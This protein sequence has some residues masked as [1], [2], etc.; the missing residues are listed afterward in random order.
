MP[1]HPPAMAYLVSRYPAISHT[2]ILREVQ[3][4]R[5]LG[6]TLFT[7]SINPPDRPVQAMEGYE[8]KR[9]KPLFLSRHKACLAPWGPCCSGP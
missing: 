6:H 2:F 7:A 4:L 1:S 3:G 5:A 8:K 9:P